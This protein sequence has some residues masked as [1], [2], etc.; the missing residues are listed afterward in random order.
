MTFLKLPDSLM[1]PVQVAGRECLKL[2]NDHFLPH[3]V[4]FS[5]H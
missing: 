2:I 4:E 3:S 5:I 1:H